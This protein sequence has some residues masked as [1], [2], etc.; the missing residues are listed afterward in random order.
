MKKLLSGVAGGLMMCCLVSDIQAAEAQNAYVKVSADTPVYRLEQKGDTDFDAYCG[1]SGPATFTVGALD[2]WELVAPASGSVTIAPGGTGGWKVKSQLCEDKRNGT[3]YLWNYFIKADEYNAKNITVPFGKTVTY[4]A[5]EGLNPDPVESDWNVNTKTKSNLP[6]ITFTRPFWGAIDWFTE[7]Y[8][9]PNPGVY[10]IHANL[11]GKPTVSDSGKM[12]VVN[13]RF[14][15]NCEH[16]YGFDDFTAWSLGPDDYYN[17]GSR[18]GYCQLPHASVRIGNFAGLTTLTVNPSG[19]TRDL[20]IVPTVATLTCNPQTVKETAD[21]SFSASSAST[22][23]A[24]LESKLDGTVMG[25]LQ[26]SAYH[27]KTR[28]CAIIAVY[29]GTIVTVDNIS[30]FTG[31]DAS[32]YER[33]LNLIYKQAVLRTSCTAGI[34]VK[35]NQLPASWSNQDLDD[36][37]NDYISRLTDGEK[38]DTY[39]F[40]LPGNDAGN[41]LLEGK[42]EIGGKYVWVY[43]GHFTEQAVYAHEIGHNLNLEEEYNVVTKEP[44]SDKANFM[45]N[46]NGIRLRKFQWDVIQ[47][48]NQ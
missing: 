16:P 36:I 7:P 31:P 44:G 42:G 34:F 38:S 21:V 23:G 40:L 22:T 20:P 32:E 6:S 45:N 1:G 9:T 39:V 12:I 43:F 30:S 27:E 15:E 19:N 37:A 5:Y 17:Y 3:I 13:T 41:P 2:S 14:T 25:T 33:V 28:K 4:K 47:G 18:T 10:Q 26:V 48:V 24:Y 46:L 11:H 8:S 29:G 35:D